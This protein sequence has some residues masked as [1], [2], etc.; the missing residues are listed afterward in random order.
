MRKFLQYILKRPL[1][2][3]VNYFAAAPKR[4]NVFRSLSNLYHGKKNMINK[5]LLSMEIDCSK[6]KF[7]VFSDQHKGNRSWADDFS[8]N[9]TNY[10]AALQY[11]NSLN[12]NFVNL[13]D[14]EEL[15]KFKPFDILKVNE[16]SFAAEAAF[17]PIRYY[18]TYGNH[19]VMWKNP[20]DT[21]LHLI[22]YFEMPLPV[23][24]GI[25]L[26][27]SNTTRPVSI[28]LTHGHQGD[29]MS[30]G[31]AFSTWVVAHFWMPLQRYLRIN[32]NS[33]SK[34]YT[35]RDKHNLMMYEWSSRKKD[36]LLITG[37]T[38]K[39]VFASGRY[40]DHP[41]N[42]INTTEARTR[43]KPSYF[44][45]GCCCYNDGDITGI[46]IADGFIR[47]IKWTG[48]ETAPKRL[49]LEEREIEKLMEDL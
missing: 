44:N 13:G 23:Y 1:E 25:V 10:I 17:Q 26:K 24:E 32:I 30:D 21:A 37:H 43:L 15:W 22:K 45:A 49:V 7:I 33:P 18:K 8:N 20:V 46:E 36:L 28:F 48:E 2:W 5:R 11:Y 38:H 19:D 40:Y 16:K 3:I 35:L 9:E 14:S 41:S 4:T 42:K 29:R 12:Y 47:L 34:N 39:P 31:N 6:D 27:T